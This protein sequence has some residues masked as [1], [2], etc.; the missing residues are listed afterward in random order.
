MA[1]R[2]GLRLLLTGLLLA[3]S[4]SQPALAGQEKATTQVVILSTS[5]RSLV[6]QLTVGDVQVEPLMR[7]GQSLFRFDVESMAQTATPGTPQVPIYGALLGVPATSGLSVR[8]L[9]AD[10]ETLRGLQV[11]P[12]PQITTEGLGFSDLSSVRTQE[13][14]VP[15]MDI[16]GRDAFHPALPA[17]LGEMG[18]LRDQPVAQILFYPV[19]F[20]PVRAE[21]RL[22]RRIVAELSWG[23]GQ[24]AARPQD[25]RTGSVYESLLRHTLLNYE[26]L[27]RRPVDQ[28]IVD[29]SAAGID[30]DGRAVAGP[31]LKIAVEEAGI[32]RLTYADLNDARFDPATIDPRMLHM[33]NQGTEIPII[34][35]GEEDGVFGPDDYVLFYGRGQHDV[36]TDTNVF[37][38]FADGIQGRRMVRR[39]GSPSGMAPIPGHF[40]VMHHA[41]QDTAYW[42]TMPGQNGEDRWFWNS[43]ISPNT[44][45]LPTF[46]DYTISLNNLSTTAATAVL[47]IRLKGYT[48]LGHRTRIYL[49]GHLVDD[50]TWR[51]QV[52][53]EH[54]VSV[55]HSLLRN[56]DN[57]V[58][59]ETVDT[60]SPVDQILVNWIEVAYWDRY[61]AED[62]QLVFGTPQAGEV[63]FEV[64]Q[65]NREDVEIFDV[66]DPF[67]P[68]QIVNAVARNEAGSFTVAFQDDVEEA[69][70]YLA[71]TETRHRSPLSIQ[72][73][74]PS[75]WR[76]PLHGADYI[77][78]THEEFYP[79]AVTLA[80]H[81]RASGLRVATVKVEDLYDEFNDGV[82]NPVAIRRF[83]QY[84]YLNWVAPAPTYVV[85]I[86]DAYQDY[87]D[88]LNTGTRVYVPSQNIESSL[89]GEVSSDN[90][91]VRVSGTDVLPDMFVG[92]LTAQNAQEAQAMVAKVIQ[93][94][95]SQPDPTWNTRVLLVADDDEPLFRE[96]S[97]H[98][99]GRLPGN[100]LV[101]RVDVEF[102]PPGDPRT[103]IID[104]VNDGSVLVN[105]A[106]H[107]EYFAWGRWDYNGAFFF[108]R[109]DL[110]AL[111]NDQRLP[112][113]TVGNC[114]NGFF[115]G[116]QQNAA[117]AE[118]L[119]RKLNGGALAVWAPTGLGY[120]SGHAIL[121]ESF[122]RAIFEDHYLALGAATTY[123]KLYTFA[124]S[125]FW[126]ELVET[127]VLFGDPA[128][129]LGI[130]VDSPSLTLA[131]PASGA[132]DV[133][134]DEPIRVTFNKPMDP[135]TVW[136]GVSGHPGLT[137]LPSWN[138][139]FT[140]VDFAH[141]NL[142]HSRT[143]EVTVYGKDRQGNTLIPGQ[144]PNP[145][146]FTVTDDRVPPDAVIQVHGSD[147]TSVLTL[148]AIEVKFTEPVR[149]GTVTYRITPHV[150]GSLRWDDDGRRALFLHD[151]FQIG[152]T[153]VF[154]TDGALDLAGNALQQPLYFTFSVGDTLEWYFPRIS[155]GP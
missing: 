7:N 104:R 28:P 81:R 88:N 80:N 58:R 35:K 92:R 100:Y 122:Y 52:Q 44:S 16:F 12:V 55:S 70:R 46:R 67:S 121:L 96:I 130:P 34:I 38:L 147:P 125:P 145:W 108:H 114:L 15:D 153:Y 99:A 6:L 124:Q 29:Q 85:L 82:F 117:L 93:Y 45:D 9:D 65:F 1:L 74:Q 21:V 63:Q 24:L 155:A 43:R 4:L 62:D 72:L 144:V 60:G 133:P 14:F 49:N 23:A 139:D 118:L 13:A 151:R 103:D 111:N 83:L 33:T 47:R 56:G 105:Y 40:P 112:V 128:T 64:R 61:V 8:V 26:M 76:S 89:F 126:G 120:A 2:R 50:Q 107:G 141:E 143:Y 77:I 119:Q 150:D 57:T 5:P 129:K 148:A 54:E 66:T 41:E 109:D 86:G 132:R 37:W 98:L 138:H 78:I 135:N 149:T 19:L 123:A 142:E 97:D 73:D 115:A 134:L 102:Y 30:F 27:K 87:R 140:M 79:S 68:A 11:A 39:D 84:A 113:V 69:S 22:Y 131:S 116:P 95:Q 71:L 59:V 25:G 10:Y 42:Q 48:S 106:G 31:A 127:Y 3:A 136:L 101:S 90:W 75:N 53:F 94:D 91:F 146:T 51:G 152:Q 154:S 17:M 137:F 36:Y 32:Y 18:Y 20:N 110:S